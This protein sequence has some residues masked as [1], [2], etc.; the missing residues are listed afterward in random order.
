MDTLVP[1]AAEN[2]CLLMFALALVAATTN[3]LARRGTPQ[4]RFSEQLF[5]WTALFAVGFTGLFTFAGHVFA[6][7]VTAKEIGWAPSPFQYEV[8]MADLTVAVLGI[9]AF[10][11]NLGFRLAATVATVTWL[12]GDAIG[13]VRQMVIANNFAP[14]NAGPW[15]WT[16]ILFPLVMVVTYYLSSREPVPGRGKLAHS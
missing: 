5:R 3:T 10:R 12:G 9:L 15:F 2:F 1:L 11:R 16:D 14:G 13:H 8:G 7:E 4:G 6:P